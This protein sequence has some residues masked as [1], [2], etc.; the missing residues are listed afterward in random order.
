MTT[1]R[2]VEISAPEFQ[3]LDF[4]PVREND[5]D[6][7]YNKAVLPRWDPVYHPFGVVYRAPSLCRAD[8][9]RLWGKGKGNTGRPPFKF[10]KGGR[11]SGSS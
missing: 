8:V 3:D 9:M 5:E 7:L 10:R 4:Y 1:D 2:R 6:I 11:P